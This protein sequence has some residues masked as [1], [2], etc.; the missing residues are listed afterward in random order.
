M[1]RWYDR[2]PI[3]WAKSMHKDVEE[4]ETERWTR[5]AAEVEVDPDAKPF[6]TSLLTAFRSMN[7]DAAAALLAERE[8]S[9]AMLRAMRGSAVW[10]QRYDAYNAGYIEMLMAVLRNHQH[11]TALGWTDE[12]KQQETAVNVRRTLWERATEIDRR[13]T[14]RGDAAYA[15]KASTARE[16]PGR[17]LELYE[18]EPT[19]MPMFRVIQ[20]FNEG[21]NAPWNADRSSTVS[22]ATVSGRHSNRRS[23]TGCTLWAR[24]TAT[25]SP[26][27]AQCR[28]GSGTCARPSAFA[29]SFPCA[30]T[31]AARRLSSVT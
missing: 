31:R 9:L 26:A 16:I 14:V 19:A 8:P 28:G 3:V 25:C 12:R 27:T 30:A 11:F 1:A 21:A 22:R 18:R 2:L 15:Q 7:L 24:R 4:F 20:R 13:L 17:L 5:I 6:A 10:H 29:D 23:P